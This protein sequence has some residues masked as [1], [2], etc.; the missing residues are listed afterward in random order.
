MI[1]YNTIGVMS[2][3]SLDGLD[4]VYV[5][6]IKDKKWSYDLKCAKTY[7]YNKRW[8]KNLSEAPTLKGLKLIELNIKFGQFVGSKI[9]DFIEVNKINKKEINL[10]SSHGHTVFH[11]P[12]KGFTYQIG[13][14]KEISITT[15]IT[16][17]SDFR[18]LD[19]AHG[20][21]GA[22][23]VPIGDLF[24]F[25]DYEYCLNIGGIANVSYDSKKKRI[26]GDIDFANINSN[27]LS[28]R[29]GYPM[30]ENGNLA[31]NGEFNELLFNELKNCSFYKES[32][33]KSLGIED[34]LSWYE[35]ILKKFNIS[36][37]NQL[38]TT[39]ILLCENIKKLIEHKEKNKLL[40]TGGGAFNSFWI[41]TLKSMG[42]KLIL[43]DKATIEYKEAIIFSF[44]GV[45]KFTNQVNTL[46]SVTGA[47]KDLKSGIVFNPKNF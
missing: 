19:V 37:N 16:S 1:I 18:S 5:Q 17:V 7:S 14:G 40:I 31:M 38:H 22:P 36:V 26:A 46:C 21:Q 8:F 24:L 41:Q 10:I 34:Y 25:S 47:K 42:I 43:P 33:P 35:P 3:T 4:I 45:L 2:G 11:Q 27:Y 29:L 30:D 28:K 13:C 39:G 6:I 9:N 20:G 12:R 23:L 44:L 15:N 32:F